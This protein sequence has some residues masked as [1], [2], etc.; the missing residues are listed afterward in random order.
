MTPTDHQSICGAVQRNCDISDARHA[1]NYTL[2]VY[3]LK[4]REF[5]RWEKGYPF[6]ASMPNDEI[7]SWLTKRERLWETL[8]NEPYVPINIDGRLMDPFNTEDINR[9]LVPRGYV[10]SGGIGRRATPH[11]FLG[12]LEK[13]VDYHGFK[14]LVSADECA[15]DLTAPPAMAL[16][17]TIFIRR[18]SLQRMIWEKVQ[19]WQWN[20]I[21]NAMARAVSFYDFEGNSD[22]ALEQMTEHELRTA[23]LHEIGEIMAGESLGKCWEELLN[24]MQRS[25]V[26]LM[27]RAVRDHLADALSTLP[28]LLDKQDVASLHFYMANMTGM[29]KDLFPSFAASYRMWVESKSLCALKR[30]LKKSKAHWLAL[31]Q[32]MLELH[33]RHGE[34]SPPYLEKLIESNRL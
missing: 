29:R 5:Y 21:E 27:A 13:Q 4:M 25:R 26:E 14:V 16:D 2:C 30:L 12:C 18:E 28:E 20:K 15:R 24:S 3:L 10:Y 11:F 17:K 31:A 22:E 1:S 23:V 9:A 6:S 19:E 33:D 34:H 8:E 7:G 32:K